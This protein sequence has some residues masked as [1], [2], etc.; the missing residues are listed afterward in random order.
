MPQSQNSNSSA[1]LNFA[2]AFCISIC[3]GLIIDNADTGDRTMTQAQQM[4][5]LRSTL[6]SITVSAS[7]LMA[8]GG[9]LARSFNAEPVRP[10]VVATGTPCNWYSCQRKAPKLTPAQKSALTMRISA[11]TNERL[12]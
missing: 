4:T 3:Y 10:N 2:L 8:S 7:M 5:S 9:Y 1:P 11:L 12:K 6:M